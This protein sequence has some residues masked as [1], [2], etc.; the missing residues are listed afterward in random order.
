MRTRVCISIDTEFS[1]G[2]AF[3]S[4]DRQ[5]VAEPMVW[6]ETGGRSHGLGFLLE[7]FERH[8]IPA[9]FFVEAA[10]RYY[11]QDQDPM[12]A[13]VRRIVG[14]G[15]EVQLHTHPCWAVF[16][17]DDW[18]E[19][20][21]R[22]PLQDEFFGRAEDDTV[23]LL[24]Q[25]QQAFAG[26]GVPAPTVFRPGNMQ[27]DDALFAALAR[28]G[29]PYSS[30]VGLAV[31]DSRDPR[32]QLYSGAHHRHGVLE[33]PVLTFQDWQ[34]GG[35]RH[36][37]TLTIAGTSFAETRLLLERA[38]EQQ[39]PLVVLLTHPFEY[40]QRRD[41]H[42]R[43]ARANALH[44][45]RLARL[46]GYLD[47]NRDRFLPTGMGEAGDAMQAALQAV[48]DERNVLLHGSGWHSIR[49]LAEQAVNDRYGS[50]ALARQG[51]PA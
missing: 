36:L 39:V 21:A 48:P 42:M 12:G 40:V 49:R 13:I 28:C 10:H 46:C 35:R 2:G 41:D 14:Q 25:G 5:P 45:D 38:H 16:E 3:T 50:W 24:R 43:T 4:A 27:H 30:C 20:V 51:V 9:T 29:I 34:L 1:I 8:R 6:C 26:W 15:H 17:H 22:E 31:F 11:F 7:Q 44:Q 18:R 23:R 19:R 37:K 32:Y 47:G 33:M